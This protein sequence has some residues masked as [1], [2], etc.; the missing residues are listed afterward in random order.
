[1]NSGD[2]P[3]PDAA[4]SSKQPQ[5][6]PVVVGAGID[7]TDPNSPLA[8]YYLQASHLVAT[9]LLC[10]FFLY[11]SIVCPLWHTDIWGHLKFGERLVQTWTFPE[12][13]PFSTLS[14]PHTPCH[15][16]QWLSQLLLY[17]V[18]AAGAWLAG[19]DEVSQTAGG[20]QLLRFAHALL[21]VGRFA[22]LLFAY[23]RASASMPLACAGMT[24]VFVLVLGP[25]AVLRPQ[26]IGELLF[27]G[28]LLA[29]SRPV[30]SRRGLFLL[31]VLLVVW[32]NA[33]GSYVAGLAL[34]GLFL[35]GRC[36]E[37]WRQERS[38]RAL[39]DD[40]QVKRLLAVLFSSVV[41]IAL[42]N[43]EGPAIYTH[44]LAMSGHPNLQDMIEWQPL[45]FGQ[46]VGGHWAYLALLLLIAVSQALSP[47]ALSPTALLM[48][49]SF[50]VWPLFQQRML[51]WWIM[52]A[53]WLLM[54]L[55]SA[56]AA[57]VRPIVRFE[58]VLSFRKTLLAIFLVILTSLFSGPVQW[59]LAGRPQRLDRAVSQATPWFLAQALK[60]SDAEK[61]KILPLLTEE[62]QKSY[63]HGRY[64]GVILA[65]EILGDYLVW[66]LPRDMPVLVYSHVHCFSEEVWQDYLRGTRG[67]LGWWEVLDRRR[68]NLVL[69]DPEL[70]PELALLLRQDAA[71]RVVLDETGDARKPDPRTRLFIAVRRQ[72]L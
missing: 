2:P 14:D 71:W 37:V 41:A 65:R 16:L 39:L 17:G 40:G 11:Y 63:A 30:L 15:Q 8:P 6:Q 43:P 29:L 70:G 55:W 4:N 32:A 26:V 46:S 48:L 3:A 68:I 36:A 34:V 27:A 69:L 38:P 53:P 59:L 22:L 23:R 10:A 42:L 72:P 49:I 19:G 45:D 67:R 64:Q 24:L 51:T 25:S 9:A 62:L 5:D 18:Y 52:L 13:E 66:S 33:H 50:G 44:T 60:H 21:Q 57:A 54:P 7:F 12:H 58:S 31:P 20:V 1:M 35:L 47:T 28:A 56:T 61:A